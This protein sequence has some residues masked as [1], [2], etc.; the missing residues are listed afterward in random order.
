MLLKGGAMKN[1]GMY[2]ILKRL[3]R[4]LYKENNLGWSQLIPLGTQVRWE[5]YQKCTAFVLTYGFKIGID[6]FHELSGIW[7]IFK[8]DELE[9][10]NEIIDIQ[11]SII[12]R[13]K[14][15]QTEFLF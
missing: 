12:G 4:E 7:K 3:S 8:P 11:R 9:E 10:N 6:K 2:E 15:S 5:Q 13:L 14:K 1:R